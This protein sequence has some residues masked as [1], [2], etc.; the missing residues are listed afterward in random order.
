MSD[1]TELRIEEFFAGRTRAHGLV[2]DRFGRVRRRFVVEIEGREDGD[3]FVLE[4]SFRFDDGEVSSRTWRVRRTGP[5]SYE[6]TAADVVGAASGEVS[7]NT[8]RWAYRLRLP[9][10]GREVIV[11]FDDRMYLG[12]DGTMLNIARMLKWGVTIGRVTIAFNRASG[13]DRRAA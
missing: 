12:A 11:G 2:E 13:P 9:I 5:H 8:L 6:G 10:G 1:H 3:V 4:E 7:G